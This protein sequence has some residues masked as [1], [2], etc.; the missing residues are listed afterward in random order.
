MPYLSIAFSASSRPALLEMGMNIAAF[1]NPMKLRDDSWFEAPTY[2]SA[3]MHGLTF[4]QIGA[5]C[6]LNGGLIGHCSVGRYCAFAPEVI[7]GAHEHPTDWLSVSRVTHVE[8]LHGWPDFVNPG[9][10]ERTRANIRPFA[11][12][13][14]ATRIGN[15]V[16]LGQRVIVRSGVTIGDGAIVAAGSVVTKDVPP[17]TIVGGTPAKTIRARFPDA[18]VE[19]LLKVQWWQYNVY[20]FDRL[21]YDRV[22]A[23]LDAIEQQAAEKGIT[24]YAPAKIT[25]ADLAAR[26]PAAAAA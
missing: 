24:P 23:A 15:D 26:F 20:D 11:G 21:P 4:L 5:F 17:Y 13:T 12:S 1:R 8:G 18:L 2:V 14:R 25:A 22:E 9:E 7:I 6:S 3:G 10:K 16:W 19:R